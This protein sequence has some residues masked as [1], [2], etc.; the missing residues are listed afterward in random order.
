MLTRLR[1]C[2]PACGRGGGSSPT[3]E[4]RAARVV[5]A[6]MMGSFRCSSAAASAVRFAA[7][8]CPQAAR[9]REQHGAAPLLAPNRQRA[10][11]QACVCVCVCLFLL[12]SLAANGLSASAPL[13][14]QQ[15]GQR[16]WS[17]N[18]PLEHCTERAS[19]LAVRWAA[20]VS[21]RCEML[22]LTDRQGRGGQVA[23]SGIFQ[24][25]VGSLR[26]YETLAP[27][28]CH[29]AWWIRGFSHPT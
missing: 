7:I 10:L 24:P 18:L 29:L 9:R 13:C 20:G 6:W 27:T 2:P 26:R 12:Y 22:T 3:T 4:L 14:G 11:L 8:A 16:Q 15:A 1:R 17:C 23:S 19:L 28:S 21:G 25:P 5:C